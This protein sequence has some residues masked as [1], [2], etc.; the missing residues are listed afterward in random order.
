MAANGE[1]RWPYLGRN[2]WP[3]TAIEPSDVMA[4][5]RAP[6]RAPAIRASAGALPLRDQSVDAA[7][8]II[9]IHHWDEEQQ[10]GV[11]ELRRVARGA[12]V[13]LTYDARVSGRMWLMADYLPEVARLDERIFPRIPLLADWL[14]GSTRVE[15]V[16]IPRIRL[17]GRLG[18]SGRILSASWTL[19]RETRPRG[20]LA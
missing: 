10:A 7:M 1:K 2:R 16:E 8:A 20:S 4:S 11:R 12:V 9:T 19:R 15:V 17:I 18:P 14:G 6:E 5:Q 3:L 13:I